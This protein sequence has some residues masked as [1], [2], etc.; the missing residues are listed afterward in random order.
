MDLKITITDAEAKEFAEV[1]SAATGITEPSLDPKTALQDAIFE[2]M[3]ATLDNHNR[4]TAT[5]TVESDIAARR[6]E[7]KTDREAKAPK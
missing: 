7:R 1:I 4:R 5:E 2:W 6:E 3:H